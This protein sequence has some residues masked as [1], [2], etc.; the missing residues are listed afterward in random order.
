MNKEKQRTNLYQDKT[1]SSFLLNSFPS[2]VQI[3]ARP[4]AM[5]NELALKTQLEAPSLEHLLVTSECSL[6]CIRKA[7]FAI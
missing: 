6:N 2:Q 1:Q 4:P 3:K 5:P 7:Q